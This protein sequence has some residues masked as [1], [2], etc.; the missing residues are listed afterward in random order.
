MSEVRIHIE[1][2]DDFFSG[3]VEWRSGWTLEIG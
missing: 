3:A 2:V 1:S